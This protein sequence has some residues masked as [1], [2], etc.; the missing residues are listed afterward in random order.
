MGLMWY[1]GARLEVGGWGGGGCGCG[2]EIMLLYPRLS[3]PVKS[4]P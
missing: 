2:G 4:R 1:V 3:R